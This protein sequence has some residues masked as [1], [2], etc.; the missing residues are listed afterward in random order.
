MENVA[1][2]GNRK[3]FLSWKK[4]KKPKQKK[5]E[6]GHPLSL[7]RRSRDNNINLGRF[8]NSK[9]GTTREMGDVENGSEVRRT[10]IYM[11]RLPR[12]STVCQKGA[13]HAPWTG[14]GGRKVF[15]IDFD[16]RSAGA[17][18]NSSVQTQ[19]PKTGLGD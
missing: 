2:E 12:R 6:L 10:S 1:A 9:Y 3:R 15:F 14:R 4:K 8:K 19:K 17:T 7:T 13:G 11:T 5:E 16:A 18:K